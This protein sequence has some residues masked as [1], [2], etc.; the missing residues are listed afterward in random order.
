MRIFSSRRRPMH[1][2][3]YP[4]ETIKRVEHPT[5]RISDQV[6][7]VSKRA[8]IFVRARHGDLG[9]KPQREVCRFATGRGP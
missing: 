4:M 2:G 9:P 7:R 8:H 1:L 6:P 5:I 3:K